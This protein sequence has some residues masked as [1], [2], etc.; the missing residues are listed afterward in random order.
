MPHRKKPVPD[1]YQRVRVRATRREDEGKQVDVGKLVALVIDIA[2]TRY[3]A[4]RHG[5]PDPFGIS[6]PAV[7]VGGPG[8]ND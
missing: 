3:Q 8:E 5:Q 4:H 7:V 6:A 1:P 2:E